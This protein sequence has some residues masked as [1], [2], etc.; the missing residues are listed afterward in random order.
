MGPFNRR[1][2][3]ETTRPKSVSACPTSGLVKPTKGV[4][5][6]FGSKSIF[7]SLIMKTYKNL[8]AVGLVAGMCLTS[9]HADIDLT[10]YGSQPGNAGDG[11]IDAWVTTLVD[12]YNAA[13]NPD[14]PA[15]A[16]LFTYKS[17]GSSPAAGYPSFGNNALSITIPTGGFDY[18][19]LKWGNGQT[20]SPYQLFYIG[21][22]ADLNAGSVTLDNT[23]NGLSDYWLFG[24]TPLQPAVPEPSTVFAGLLLL[25]PLGV[26]VFRGIRLN[27][28]A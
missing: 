14:L 13:N 24:P 1:K 19:A 17:T 16:S 21:T 9:A 20:A 10:P 22:T 2:L 23:K 8:Y 3:K 28:P 26:G 5:M 25:L 27:H 4:N 11:T 15:P 6:D 12:N 18:V 7:R